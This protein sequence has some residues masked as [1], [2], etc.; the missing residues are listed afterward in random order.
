MS[1][2]YRRYALPFKTDGPQEA[3]MMTPILKSVIEHS[4]K[5]YD[6]EI[7]SKRRRRRKQDEFRYMEL[8]ITG[9][10]KEMI[11]QR[12]TGQTQQDKWKVFQ[13]T[14]IPPDPNTWSV[15]HTATWIR[16]LNDVCCL[17]NT[18]SNVVTTLGID[19]ATICSMTEQ[20][21]SRKF[22]HHGDNADVTFRHLQFW[23]TVPPFQ[24]EERPN[25]TPIELKKMRK[26]RGK[27]RSKK[28]D[29]PDCN[30][31]D[32]NSTRV[33]STQENFDM[34]GIKAT[35]STISTQDEQLR[36]IDMSLSSR[37][38]TDLK[39]SPIKSDPVSQETAVNII[40][41]GIVN[42][43]NSVPGTD[44][45]AM[46]EDAPDLST[47]LKRKRG[48]PPK[49]KPATNFEI[50]Q[51]THPILWK[52]LL[53]MLD[54]PDMVH[55]VQWVNREEGL[56]KFDS[57]Q[58]EFIAVKWGERKGNTRMTYPKMARALR[59]YGKVGILMGNRRRLHYKFSPTYMKK[60]PT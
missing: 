43:Y 54:N 24:I 7:P 21:F 10:M 25:I 55:C 17:E 51:K 3:V 22:Y 57:G 19:G 48:R 4:K 38:K 8:K 6:N 23:K 2:M 53:E 11:D 37:K 29:P 16:W 33:G 44:T 5:N 46:N 28:A 26:S 1:D 30:L 50:K 42:F 13:E 56:F 27:H 15:E 12:I 47:L 41:T 18:F 35:E 39:I 32:L 34:P 59:H 60:I 14:G 49:Q 31:N 58:K 36:P 9:D 40:P 45:P 20:E 52:F